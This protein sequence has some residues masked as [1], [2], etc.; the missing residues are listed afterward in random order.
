M[1]LG[2]QLFGYFRL[3]VPHLAEPEPAVRAR[4]LRRWVAFIVAWQV[5]VLVAVAA[6]AIPL[7][8]AHTRGLAWLA[9]GLGAVLGTAFPLQL[10]IS[11]ILR[12]LR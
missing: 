11:R 7:A 12:A 1:A 9:P 2:A 3:L 5:V 8:S 10:A 6:Y 4:A